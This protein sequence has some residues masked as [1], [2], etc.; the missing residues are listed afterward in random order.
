M[1][2]EIAMRV[3][4]GFGAAVLMTVTTA[5]TLV[6][7]AF[8]IYAGLKLYLPAAGASAVTALIFAAI[9][10]GVFVLGPQLFGTKSKPVTASP[11]R[12]LNPALLHLLSEAATAVI[13][14]AANLMLA[15]QLRRQT[16]EQ[17]PKH[18][19]H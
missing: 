12:K 14:I 18:R 16:R 19:R 3:G 5:I 1:L 9:A 10:A 15:R 4:A 13:P 6:A 17:K 2:K 7:A 8:G 11:P